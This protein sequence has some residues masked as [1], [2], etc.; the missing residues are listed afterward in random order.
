MTAKKVSY[1]N[2][3]KF[4]GAFIAYLIGSGFATG[5][6][7]LQYFTSYGYYGLLV[8]LFTVVCLIYVGGEFM[9]VGY[10]ARFSNVNDIYR[11]Y[12]GKY[13]GTF[14]DYFATLFIFMSYI[15]MISGA[16]A[17][18]EQ[19][20]HLSPVIGGIGMAIVSV[21][22][23]LLGLGKI[24]DV[25]GFIGPLVV[26]IAIVV[27]IGGIWLAP[28][29]IAENAKL[30]AEKQI[31]ITKVGSN[32]F[33]SGVSYV[34][35]IM[36]WLAAFLAAMGTEA[37]NKKEIRFGTALGAIGFTA[38]AVIL[39]LGL[40]AHLGVVH[41]SNIP[42]LIIAGMI[43]EPLASIFSI[44]IL[45]GIF[46][47]AV[48]LLWSVSARFSQERTIKFYIISIAGAVISSFVAFDVPFR[49]VVNIIY[50][51]NGYIGIIIIFFMLAKTLGIRRFFSKK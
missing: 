9:T 33:F 18:V 34:G 1:I 5:Q 36:L 42:S 20:Y 3:I 50:G 4:A 48:P 15:V 25:I 2:V 37:N 43:W 28:D 49:F 30:I 39:M 27:G 6:E 14:Y 45:A 11:Y 31:E 46:T 23:V 32:W 38:G 8:G 35:F 40:L 19:Y 7:I 51:I 29:G 26:I 21:A 44:V 10:Q 16:G 24:V 47:T 17:T 12:C 41:D 13:I 22:V